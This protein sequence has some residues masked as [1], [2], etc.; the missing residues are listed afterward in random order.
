MLPTH[1]FLP[2]HCLALWESEDP[3]HVRTAICPWPDFRLPL[4]EFHVMSPCYGGRDYFNVSHLNELLGKLRNSLNED[5]GLG[6]CTRRLKIACIES[7]IDQLEGEPLPEEV[8][9][10]Y[11]SWVA[12]LR[13]R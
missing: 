1:P 8:G 5:G 13:N 6:Q 12:Y 9:Q 10:G 2:E 3:A 11:R 4:D 7:W